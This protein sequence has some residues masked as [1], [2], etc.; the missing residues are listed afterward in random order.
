M[1]PTLGS[2]MIKLRA[3]WGPPAEAEPSGGVASQVQRS[4]S[5]TWGHPRPGL[6]GS[7]HTQMP[8]TFISRWM[9]NSPRNSEGEATGLPAR[10]G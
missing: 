6:C 9:A 3:A 5:Q 4:W 2:L 8:S 10:G 7:Q 1:C